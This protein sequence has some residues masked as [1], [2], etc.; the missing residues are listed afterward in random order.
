MKKIREDIIY[1]DKLCF[2]QCDKGFFN[3]CDN[4]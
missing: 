1:I 3:E 2:I 4:Y